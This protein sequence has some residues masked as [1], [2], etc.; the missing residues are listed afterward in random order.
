MDPSLAKRRGSKDTSLENSFLLLSYLYLGEAE[1]QFFPTLLLN[2]KLYM[3]TFLQHL[4]KGR[5]WDSDGSGGDFLSQK[6]SQNHK[7]Q[8]TEVWFH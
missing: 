2:D 1:W 8:T 4:S 5:Q 3:L 6:A 7:M